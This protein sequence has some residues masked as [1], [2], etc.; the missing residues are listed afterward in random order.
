MEYTTVG[1]TSLDTAFI[2]FEIKNGILFITY[3]KGAELDINT[4]RELYEL[5]KRFLGNDSYPTIVID[6]GLKKIDKASR[7]FL[8]KEGIENILAG[9]F[10]LPNAYSAALIRFFLLVDKPK[11]PYMVF[12][13]IE[14]ALVWLEQYKTKTDKK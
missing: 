4:T 2:Q 1:S 10:V 8:A 13:D 5:K 11:V 6:G 12:T 7:D 14:K 3:K 9:A